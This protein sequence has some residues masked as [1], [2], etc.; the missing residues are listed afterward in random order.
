MEINFII[1][2]DNTAVATVLFVSESV[3]DV[4]GFT[5]EELTG[6]NGYVLTHPDERPALGLIHTS[7]VGNEHMSSI[8]VYRSR[9]KDGHYV[10]MDVIVHY[11]YD[12]IIC[13]NFAVISEDSIKRKMRINSADEVYNIQHDGSI[14]LTGAWNDSQ[15]R[16]K[17][18]L[19]DTHPWGANNQLEAKKPQ[20]PRFCLILNRYSDKAIIVFA[21]K[22]CE[23]MVNLNQVHCIGQSLYDYVVPQDKENVKKQV[24]LSKSTD[25]IS[26]LRFD[27]AIGENNSIALEAVISGT[28]DGLVMVARITPTYISI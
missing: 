22:M 23:S 3:Y 4:L 7:T 19:A 18:A 15:E 6:L 14:R 17:Q 10:Q 25:I 9:H 12:T 24:E 28:Y 21:T 1:I 27:W 5:P 16:M 8:T 26:R 2:C 20:E 11:C 13:T